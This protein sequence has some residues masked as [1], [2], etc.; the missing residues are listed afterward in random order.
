VAA[1]RDVSP[2][3][4]RSLLVALGI[5]LVVPDA[6]A[7]QR[8]QVALPEL[9][10]DVIAART[11][12][13]QLAAG[14]AI[15]AGTYVRGLLA[16]GGGLARKRSETE[17][18]ARVDGGLRFL[19]DPFREQTWGLYGAGG[20]SLLYDGFDRWR[21]LVTIA[22]GVEREGPGRWGHAIEVG[23]GGGARVGLVLR[24]HAAGTR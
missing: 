23:L 19:L 21:G 3:S 2:P 6:L 16:V 17:P 20:I 8:R 5:L 13:A 18:S 22:V 7:A 14:I 15:P 24:P 10:L 4:L 1:A 9:R 11:T 12:M